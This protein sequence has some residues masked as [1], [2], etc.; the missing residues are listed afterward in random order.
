MENVYNTTRLAFHKEKLEALAR[1]E[2]TAPIHARVKPTNRCDHNCFYC[3]YD[4]EFGYILSERLNRRDEIPK[5]KMMQILDDFKDIGVKAVTFSGGGEPLVYPHIEDALRKTLE[6]KIDLSIIT[7][8][9]KLS[10]KK[11]ELLAQAKWVRISAEYCDEKKFSE[12]RRVPERLFYEEIDNI[13]NFAEIKKDDCELGISFVVNDKNYNQIYNTA[14]FFKDLGV[15]HI[16][17]LSLYTPRG[18]FEYHSKFKDEAIKQINKA[19]ELKNNNFSVYSTYEDDFAFAGT[20]KRTY[21]RC[22]IMETIPV[23]GADCF[24][25][26]C[27]DKAYSSTGVLGSIKEKSFKKVWFSKEA[28]NIFKNFNA[29]KGCRHHCGNDCR[30]I[31]IHKMLSD[32]SNIDAY[33][34][35]SDKHK[36]FI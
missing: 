19:R 35:S 22:L 14:Q 1:G 2:V 30:N 13:K 29:E 33:K 25:Y 17:F 6:N 31:S 24:I 18:F 10:G 3:S 7:N 8:G 21:S 26:F 27:H 15:N 20:D 34:P 11:A 9:Q 23:I 16:R 36:N 5:D 28:L 4:P 12:I 32:L